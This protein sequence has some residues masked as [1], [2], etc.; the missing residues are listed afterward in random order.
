[1]AW[2]NGSKYESSRSKASWERLRIKAEK[3]T[4]KRKKARKKRR[5]MI[6]NPAEPQNPERSR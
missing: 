1:M 6:K 5:I 2:H 4:A 3:A